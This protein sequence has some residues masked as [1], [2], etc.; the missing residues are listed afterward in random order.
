MF[1]PFF[2]DDNTTPSS[3]AELVAGERAGGNGEKSFGSSLEPAQALYGRDKE[4]NTCL[5]F[6]VVAHKGERESRE[7]DRVC[8]LV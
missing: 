3:L 5:F 7:K 6:V 1:C 2:S 4:F 8:V